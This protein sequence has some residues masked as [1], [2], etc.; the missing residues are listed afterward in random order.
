M[1]N[2]AFSRVVD[3]DVDPDRIRLKWLRGFGSRFGIRIQIWIRIW[4]QGIRKRGNNLI[5]IIF[6]S[7]F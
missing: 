1:L 4:L 6:S 2:I 7:F 5:F 3:A